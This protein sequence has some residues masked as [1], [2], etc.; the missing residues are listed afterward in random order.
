[1]I[2]TVDC[3]NTHTTVGC[4]DTDNSVCA[5]FRIP[6]DR[7]DTEFGYAAK[8]K[9]IFDLQKI[10]LALVQGAVISCVVPSMTDILKSAVR[11][12]SGTEPL[13][14]G[15]GVKTGLHICIN[16]P[17]TVAADLVATAVAAKEEYPLPC[18]IV[19]MGTATTV[20]VVDERARFIGGA[21]LPGAGISLDAL[22]S[23]AALLPHV[24][25]TSPKHAIGADTAECMKSGI[26]YGTAGAVD[27][28][29]ERFTQELGG[30]PASIV[31]TGGIAPLIASHCKHTMQVDETLLLRGLKRIWD[32]NHQ[33]RDKK[34]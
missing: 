28:L 15:A 26:V 6:T 1:M 24:D 22:A 17:G 16:D 8:M 3:G 19:D 25:M 21:I 29:L 27:G 20:T 31:A 14:V 11:L 4:V 2:L 12:L 30:A 9:E 5:V 13:V 32:K 34:E 33:T 10:D 23:R 7:R 18:M